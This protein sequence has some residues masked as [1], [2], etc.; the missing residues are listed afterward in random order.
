M[1]HSGEI[2]H[3]LVQLDTKQRSQ[4]RRCGGCCG[5]EKARGCKIHLHEWGG[6]VVTNTNPRGERRHHLGFLWG[7]FPLSLSFSQFFS[8]FEF[9][10]SPFVDQDIAKCLRQRNRTLPRSPGSV[11]SGENI[12]CS[13]SIMFNNL[14]S[15][16]KTTKQNKTKSIAFC[17]TE[18]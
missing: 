6:V 8:C 4:R 16:G 2:I 12:N 5:D 9:Y 14:C 3:L 1:R 10:V 18:Y 7:A 13:N 15:F 11:A 17:Y